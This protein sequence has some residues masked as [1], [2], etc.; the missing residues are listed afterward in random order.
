VYSGCNIGAGHRTVEAIKFTD[1]CLET[2]RYAGETCRKRLGVTA[3]NFDA[4]TLRCETL[5]GLLDLASGCQYCEALR[6]QIVASK[7]AGNIFYFACLTQVLDILN[8]AVP[9]SLCP[10]ERSFNKI[11][12]HF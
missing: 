4:P 12:V 3:R 7:T 2:E 1:F 5:L 9:S 6:D 8:P 10:P 11:I